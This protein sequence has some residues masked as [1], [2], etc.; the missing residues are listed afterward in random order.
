MTFMLTSI[1]AS[2]HADSLANIAIDVG[3]SQLSPGAI[4]ARGKPE[5]EFNAD[6]AKSLQQALVSH[7]I[8]S[9]LI[10]EDG[11]MVDIKQRSAK[12]NTKKASLLL[13]IHH[14]SAQPHYLRKWMWQGRE[15][16]YSDQFSGFS[17]FISRKNPRL[18][19]SLDCARMIGKSLKHNGFSPSN[20]HAEPIKGENRHWADK[21]AGVY[22]YDDL[23]VLKTAD[24]PAVLIEAGVIIN[25]DD[26]HD[27]QKNA[28]KNLIASAITEGVIS[29]M[30]LK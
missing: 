13:S 11:N 1:G 12:A 2:I 29:C 9:F 25:R 17:L 3:H 21:N 20:H 23:I 5:F 27:L 18:E 26:E 4:S 16:H 10:G 7:Q 24:M 30:G 15:L 28:T 6:L 22:Y 8:K 14:D 19:K